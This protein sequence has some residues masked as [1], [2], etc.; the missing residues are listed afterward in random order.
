MT[1]STRDMFSVAFT[2]GN[3]GMFD[4]GRDTGKYNSNSSN[5]G[6]DDY[7]VLPVPTHTNDNYVRYFIGRLY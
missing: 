1:K 6:G 2:T 4:S 3:L 7:F 5:P